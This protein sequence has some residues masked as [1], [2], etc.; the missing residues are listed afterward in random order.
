MRGAPALRPAVR[1]IRDRRGVTLIEFAFVMPLLLFAI[2]GLAEL[3]NM[4][5]QGQRVS[6]AAL[7]IADNAGRLGNMGMAG[8]EKISEAQ[9]NDALMSADVQQPSLK[10]NDRARIILT[11]LER[12]KNDGQ[13]LHWQR[14]R[15]KLAHVSSW[16]V[17]NDGEHGKAVPGMGPANARIVADPEQPVMFVEIAYRRQALIFPALV[18]DK[19]IVEIAA[20]PIRV[21]RD[22][23]SVIPGD[24]VKSTC[25]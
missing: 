17:E 21:E 11:S 18:G 8:P 3:A 19:P 14:C 15:G 10:L 2:L 12:N 22:T 9:I 25:K 23:S 4:A 13:W 24:A 20:M 16:G 7:L 1:L 6:Q 5:L